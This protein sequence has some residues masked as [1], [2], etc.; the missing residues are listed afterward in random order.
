MLSSTAFEK[1]DVNAAPRAPSITRWS[2]DKEKGIVYVGIISF[3]LWLYIGFQMLLETP[4]IATSGGL[5]IGVK[6]VPP[7]PLSPNQG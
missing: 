1:K 4:I 6:Y 3:D 5:I 2:Y 7:I